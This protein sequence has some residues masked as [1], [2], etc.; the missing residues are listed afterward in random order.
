MF[1]FQKFAFNTF[2]TRVCLFSKGWF[3]SDLPTEFGTKHECRRMLKKIT[4]SLHFKGGFPLE[5]FKRRSSEATSL[6]VIHHQ[7]STDYPSES[8]RLWLSKRSHDSM[9]NE[10]RSKRSF[11]WLLIKRFPLKG[12]HW[13]VFTEKFSSPFLLWLNFIKPSDSK[14]S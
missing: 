7:S 4:L 9:S 2:K 8:E 5:S 13:K 14:S 1:G 3:A 6:V 10:A 12:F 11:S